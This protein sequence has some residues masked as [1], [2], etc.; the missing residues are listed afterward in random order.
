MTKTHDLSTA[1]R[2]DSPFTCLVAPYNDHQAQILS[3]CIVMVSSTAT[4]S[5]DIMGIEDI[6]ICQ[7]QTNGLNKVICAGF[8][9]G[10]GAGLP[11][12]SL[13]LVCVDGWPAGHPECC[14]CRRLLAGHLDCS[15]YFRY[16]PCCLC[17]CTNW[18]RGR[19]G[20]RQPQL[21]RFI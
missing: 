2:S 19:T 5:E 12:D 8:W 9:Q 21:S 17:L 6:M 10:I 11:A 14:Q 13:R 20:C 1:I 18:L 16:C 3:F 15:Y 7:L 4:G